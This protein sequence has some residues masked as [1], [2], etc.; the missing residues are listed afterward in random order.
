MH[1]LDENH[2]GGPANRSSDEI[3]QWLVERFATIAEVDATEL[4]VDRPF[5]DYHLDS[6]VA[7]TVTRELSAWLDRELSLTLF[8]EYPTIATLSRALPQIN[9]P[10][11]AT[12]GKQRRAE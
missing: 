8:W 11:R 4:D 2:A 6:S 12:D 7:V 5:A 10:R 3:E 9:L 1:V